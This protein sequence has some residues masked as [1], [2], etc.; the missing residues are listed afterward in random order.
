MKPGKTLTIKFFAVYRLNAENRIQ[1][2]DLMNWPADYG[3]TK[4]PRLGPS[5][6]QRAAYLSYITA[7]NNGDLEMFPLF[8]HPEIVVSIPGKGELKG[9]EGVQ[10]F[11]K[12]LFQTVRETITIHRLIADKD[13]MCVDI[14]SEF[15][16]V[17]D[18]PNFHIQ[19]LKKGES[20][21]KHSVVM[22]ELKDGL[23]YRVQITRKS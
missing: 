13:G 16:A 3:V 7:F 2:I 12:S 23:I 5:Y 17:A 10:G 6:G 9:R 4:E 11:Y 20:I 22:Y 14:T 1:R 8:Y 18:A 21:T 15:T 19:A